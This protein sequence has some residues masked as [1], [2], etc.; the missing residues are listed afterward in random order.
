MA[1]LLFASPAL[2]GAGLKPA[3]KP[4]PGPALAHVVIPFQRISWQ[5]EFAPGPSPSPGIWDAALALRP[6]GEARRTLRLV[7]I[8]FPG[9]AP[10]PIPSA[11]EAGLGSGCRF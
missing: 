4:A 6:P 10:E 11:L 1:L 2:P 7:P 9:A 5:P 3:P 8:P